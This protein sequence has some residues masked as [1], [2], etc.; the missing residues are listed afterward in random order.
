MTY[1]IY[2]TAGDLVM[3]GYDSEGEVC[4]VA[5]EWANQ[6]GEGCTVVGD[7]DETAA[8]HDVTPDWT[9]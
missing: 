5:K 3:T 7:D 2:S 8:L 1:S 6:H 4:A 9:E